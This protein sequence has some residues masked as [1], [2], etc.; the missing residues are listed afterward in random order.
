MK[1]IILNEINE[2]I[3][4]TQDLIPQ[5]IDSIENAANLMISVVKSGIKFYGVEMEEVPPMLST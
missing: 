4:V 3:S 5:S 2:N 1:D